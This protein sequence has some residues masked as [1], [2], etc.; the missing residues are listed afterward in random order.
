MRPVRW[1]IA[2]FGWVATDFM[3]PAIEAAGDRLVAVADPSLAALA[4]ASRRGARTYT[5]VCALA[6][7][8]DVEAIYVATPNHLHR[9]AVEAAAASGK[10]VLCEKPIAATLVDA[11]AAVA[12]CRHAGVLY[13]TAFDQRHHP[14]HRA[15]RDAL[16]A[17]RIGTPTAI[18]IVYA[19][20]LGPTWS[21]GRGGDNWR[22][23]GAKAGGGAMMDLAPHGLDL[24]DFLLGEPLD[25]MVSMLQR[26]VHA[27]A[28]DDGAMLV[29]R[30]GSGVLVSLHVAY[31]CPDALPRRRLEVTGSHG[32]IVAENTMGQDAGGTL[33]LT[34]G[35]TG[36][37]EILPILDHD[38]SPFL[39]QVRRFGDAVRSGRS[40]EFSG[41]RDLH[42]MRLLAEA[43]RGDIP[44]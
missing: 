34:D 41:E 2:G 33:T 17:G 29:G 11:E 13:G 15:L 7:D 43:Y 28:V 12:A 10:A 39:A 24:V 30:T 44:S 6:S 32:M 16:A 22:I 5:D 31:N 9:E 19:C 18:R 21:A 35:T 3:A 25:T 14:A 42:T 38:L 27:Y 4:D 40:N 36:L 37:P 26:R 20:W 8:P 23:D 1:G